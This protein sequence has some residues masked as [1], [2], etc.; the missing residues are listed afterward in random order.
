[1]GAILFA[2][3]VKMKT[4]MSTIKTII[5]IM[6]TI[7]TIITITTTKRLNICSKI[8]VVTK[9]TKIK[10]NSSKMILKNQK[11]ITSTMIIEIKNITKIITKRNNPTKN[12]YIKTTMATMIISIRNM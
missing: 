4:K 5:I 12:N 10:G 3:S 6:I 2:K 9:R 8:R 1:M 7:K 11:M